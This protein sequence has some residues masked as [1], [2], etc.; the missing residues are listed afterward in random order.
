M[1]VIHNLL[2]MGKVDKFTSNNCTKTCEKGCLKVII[3]KGLT[4][5]VLPECCISLFTIVFSKLFPYFLSIIFPQL[6]TVFHNYF[7]D[8]LF[9][10]FIG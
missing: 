1:K 8:I 9:F 7:V 3:K 6:S 4:F 10:I 5:L 2:I